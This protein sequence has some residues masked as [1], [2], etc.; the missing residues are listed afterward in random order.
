M[1]VYGALFF[2]KLIPT[3]AP[4]GKGTNLYRLVSATTTGMVGLVITGGTTGAFPLEQDASKSVVTAK[5]R[6]IL[7]INS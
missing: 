5:A 1:P 7:F 6:N 4:I 2:I 3:D